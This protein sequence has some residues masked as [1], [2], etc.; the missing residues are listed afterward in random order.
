MT[1][2]KTLEELSTL[3]KDKEKY[4]Y[5]NIPLVMLKDEEVSNRLGV[6]IIQ[7]C[8][9]VDEAYSQIIALEKGSRPKQCNIMSQLEYCNVS[10]SL[11]ES[12]SKIKRV[13]NWLSHSVNMQETLHS[14]FAKNLKGL[15]RMEKYR[16]SI[17]IVSGSLIEDAQ[18]S[19]LSA[20]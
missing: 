16:T 19:Y 7:F 9:I 6:E 17:R 2:R 5:E 14:V 4:I 12:L 11:I 3:I 1:K 20:K 13:R 18:Y 15:D 10:N 8:S